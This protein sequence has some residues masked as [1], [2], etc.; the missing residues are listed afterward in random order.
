MA[1]SSALRSLFLYLLFDYG[2]EHITFHRP[3]ALGKHITY[4]PTHPV[5]AV[6]LSCIHFQ[7]ELSRVHK[8]AGSMLM[9]W[10]FGVDNRTPL[11]YPS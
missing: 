1:H 5:A 8:F 4:Q 7:V 6:L 3:L 10:P 11:P 9:F 2:C